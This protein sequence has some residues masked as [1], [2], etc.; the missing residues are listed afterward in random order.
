MI[1]MVLPC[2]FD[3]SAFPQ[4]QQKNSS[5]AA[6]QTPALPSLWLHMGSS[7]SSEEFALLPCILKPCFWNVSLLC[8]A[9]AV[10]NKYLLF[11]QLLC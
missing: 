3:L 9:L 4:L 1:S 10:F 11:Q 6:Q 5:G 7:H 2:N 8:L